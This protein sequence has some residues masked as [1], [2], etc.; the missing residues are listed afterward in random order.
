MQQARKSIENC[1]HTSQQ[2]RGVPAAAARGGVTNDLIGTKTKIDCT[3]FL[4]GGKSRLSLSP[5]FRRSTVERDIQNLSDI[6]KGERLNAGT[7]P[8]G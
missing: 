7:F 5:Q 6:M 2:A 4:R 8:P 1:A 3:K